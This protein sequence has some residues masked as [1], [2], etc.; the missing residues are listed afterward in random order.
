MTAYMQPDL[1]VTTG[2]G[3]KMIAG[4]W[5]PEPG[6]E[7]YPLQKRPDGRYGAAS[8]HAARLRTRLTTAATTRRRT[9]RR[10]RLHAE[11]AGSAH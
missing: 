4:P 11:A 3:T 10:L 7:A 9:T 8:P 6:N 5:L 2:A 1:L